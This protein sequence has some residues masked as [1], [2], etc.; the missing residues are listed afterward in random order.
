[1]I[2]LTFHT[3]QLNSHVV[4]KYPCAVAMGR[5]FG[6]RATGPLAGWTTVTTVCLHL[7]PG[8]SL[9]PERGLTQIS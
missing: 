3:T 2:Y 9:T 1:M 7:Q 4:R 8:H 5:L 6:S